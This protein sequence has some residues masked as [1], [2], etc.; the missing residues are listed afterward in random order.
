LL[1]E[2]AG[3]FISVIWYP[4][5]EPGSCPRHISGKRIKMNINTADDLTKKA[6]LRFTGDETTLN[7]EKRNEQGAI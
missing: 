7:S 3:L 4:V 1:P 2:K 5:P 6:M